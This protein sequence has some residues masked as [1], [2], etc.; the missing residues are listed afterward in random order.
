MVQPVPTNE[1]VT[2]KSQRYKCLIR[3][4]GNTIPKHTCPKAKGSN[5]T[6]GYSLLWALNSLRGNSNYW[7]VS[8]EEVSQ[9]IPKRCLRNEK[10]LGFKYVAWDVR[11]LGEKE[12]GLDKT[13]NDNNIKIQ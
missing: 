12:E 10:V 8:Q 9:I 5:P 2:T 4:G 1:E 7:Q 6:T 13:V 11:G 3:N